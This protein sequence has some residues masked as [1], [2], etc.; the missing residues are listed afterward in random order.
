MIGAVIGDVVGSEYEFNNTNRYDFPMLTAKATFTDD[1]VCACA[2]ASMLMKYGGELNSDLVVKELNNLCLAH[3]NAGYGYYYLHWLLSHFKRPYNSCGNGSAMRIGAV[4]WFAN[5]EKEVCMLSDLISGVTHNHPEGLKGAKVT[6]MCVYYARKYK[7]KEKVRE[8]AKR[9]YNLN[10]NYR[11]EQQLEHGLEVCQF[12]VPQAIYCFLISDSFEDCLRKAVA[13]GG[14]SDTL[15][16]IACSIAE[17]YY[18][19][20]VNL[21]KAVLAKLP[22]DLKSIVTAFDKKYCC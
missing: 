15:A 14:D 22:K 19:V 11:N 21:K 3:P 6:A 18:G 7:D 8:Y 10:F 17:A 20:P 12:T 13:L 16:C 9:Y 1:T 4:G 5:S 2:V